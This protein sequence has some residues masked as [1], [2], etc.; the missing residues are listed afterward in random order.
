MSCKKILH[1]VHFC[2][3]ALAVF[4]M[5]SLPEK[6]VRLASLF[7]EVSN[8]YGS[9]TWLETFSVLFILLA[10]FVYIPSL[11]TYTYTLFSPRSTTGYGLIL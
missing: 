10:V 1:F 5:L 11:S 4:S 8:S 6:K 9:F 7:S 2:F 3:V